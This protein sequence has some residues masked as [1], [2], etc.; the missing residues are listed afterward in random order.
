MTGRTDIGGNYT[1]SRLWG[2]FDGENVASGPVSSSAFQ[3]PE[4]TQAS[5]NIPDGD[6]SS[7]QRHRVV[8][9]DQLRRGRRSTG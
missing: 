7:D 4:Y 2:N 5:W 6:L 3:Y 8:D 9:V 1:L